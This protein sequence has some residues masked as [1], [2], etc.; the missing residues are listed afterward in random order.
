L[1]LDFGRSRLIGMDIER[2]GMGIEGPSSI[3]LIIVTFKN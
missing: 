1:K 3:I 2:C